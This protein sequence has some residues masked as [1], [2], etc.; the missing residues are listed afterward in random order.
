M[1][2]VCAVN[3]EKVGAIGTWVE[4]IAL[5]MLFGLEWYDGKAQHR[6]TL[7]QIGE[8]QKA[9]DA[10]LLNAQALIEAERPWMVVNPN[11]SPTG[12]FSFLATNVGRT[13]A[14]IESVTLD[15]TFDSYK[16]ESRQKPNYATVKYADR[17]F[18]Q[19][20]AGFSLDITPHPIEI[21][22][23]ARLTH[24]VE[25]GNQYLI[26]DGRIRYRYAFEVEEPSRKLHETIWSCYFDWQ[27]K[28]LVR[29]ESFC[30]FT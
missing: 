16:D 2:P 14:K 23:R 10:A 3:W 11:Q 27:K 4:A 22:R 8:S 19:P 1:S 21:I 7:K 15:F 25:L 29:I 26:F 5:A 13:P 9:A 18:I 20:S 17:N 24:N 12:A 28:D 6:E 30:T